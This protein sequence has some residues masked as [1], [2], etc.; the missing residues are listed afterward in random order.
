MFC[1]KCGKEIEGSMNFCE[2][3]SEKS[4]TTDIPI[5]QAENKAATV[6]DE[7]YGEAK[8]LAKEVGQGAKELAEKGIEGYK[9][10]K[11]MS[12]EEQ[13]EVVAQ[14]KEKAKT[15]ATDVSR[16]AK[17]LAEKGIEGYKDFKNM[18]KEEQ[19]EAVEQTKV[20][21]KNFVSKEI[22]N[23]K[24]FKNLT[25]KQKLIRIIIPVLALLIFGGLFGGKSYKNDEDS[26][27]ECAL[28]QVDSQIYGGA[29]VEIYD[30]DCI[31]KDG[32]G[33]YI[34]TVTSERNRM[35]TRWVV[36]VTLHP[37]G[38]HYKAIANYH[39]TS[40]GFSEDDW[41]KEYKNNDDYGWGTKVKD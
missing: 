38:E 2:E 3:C 29:A 13:Q 1:N 30:P 20:K 6:T 33:R 37:D 15:V 21:A 28:T 4:E 40:N 23:Y 16:S 34:V 14:T 19:Q 35:E 39:G 27:I 24:N 36:L 32:K 17:E 7:A 11:G 22:E 12:K 26:A 18:S 9:N 31:A 8:Q 5:A 25:T 10:F 41:I